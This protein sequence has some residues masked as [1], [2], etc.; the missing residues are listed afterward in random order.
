MSEA[1][2][3]SA[4][5]LADR[6]AL[7]AELASMLGVHGPTAGATIDER[8]KVASDVDQQLREQRR[9]VEEYVDAAPPDERTGRW[10][11]ADCIMR[12]SMH[13]SDSIRIL[14]PG[15]AGE[16]VGSAVPPLDAAGLKLASDAART[17]PKAAEPASSS[18]DDDEPAGAGASSS[19]KGAKQQR[20]D[21]DYSKQFTTTAADRKTRGRG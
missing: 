1:D 12:V 14:P 15:E 3:N 8:A 7:A 2:N 20:Q 21:E 11:L 18:E 6:A 9:L 4:P 5:S 13:P 16:P 17:K 19:A 10:V